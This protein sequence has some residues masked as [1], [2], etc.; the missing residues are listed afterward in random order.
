MMRNAAETE[1]PIMP[2]T[3]PKASN[4]SLIADDVAATTIDVI[5]TIL[6]WTV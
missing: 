1:V 6:I 3:F 5:M 2:P 4:L